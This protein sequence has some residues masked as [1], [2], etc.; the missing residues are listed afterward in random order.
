MTV[1]L[2]YILWIT[3]EMSPIPFD[4]VETLTRHTHS[5]SKVYPQISATAFR[6][7]LQTMHSFMS[8]GKPIKKSFLILLSAISTIY[9]TSDHF[10]LVVSPAILVMAK[11][12]ENNP[13]VNLYNMAA[14]AYVATLCAQVCYQ[15]DLSFS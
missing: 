12:L 9:P 6:G 7:H 2:D 5:L 10:H 14:G 3:D 11:Y 13:P 4:V 15:S 1:L 8:S